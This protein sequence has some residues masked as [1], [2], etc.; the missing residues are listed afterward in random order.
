[1]KFG[2]VRVQIARYT[3]FDSER[4]RIEQEL[5]ARAETFHFVLRTLT[6]LAIQRANCESKVISPLDANGA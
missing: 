6:Q 5:D 1:M 4:I 3:H 2:T